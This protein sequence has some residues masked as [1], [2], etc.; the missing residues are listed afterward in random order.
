QLVVERVAVA[1][2][3]AGVLP[4]LLAVIAGHDD[5]RLLLHADRAERVPDVAHGLVGDG[6]VAVVTGLE[7][8]ALIACRIH[9]T[10]P[11]LLRKQEALPVV[12]ETPRRPDPLEPPG[13]GFGSVALGLVGHVGDV[14]LV[15]MKEGT[16]GAV[17]PEPVDGSGHANV[18]V[19]ALLVGL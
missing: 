1:R 16:R 5:R 19:L 3:A 6:D 18:A 11:H 4:E 10:A 12:I 13:I 17:L 7:I 2:A 8:L 9:A 14:G 15:K